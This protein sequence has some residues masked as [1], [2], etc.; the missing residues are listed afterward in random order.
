MANI[1]ARRALSDLFKQGTEIRFGPGPDGKPLGEIGPFLRESGERLPPSDDQVVMWITPAD[2]VQREQALREANARRAASIVRAKTDKESEEH[3][4]AMAFLVDMSDETLVDYVIIGDSNMR[5][6]QAE[7]EVLSD[8]EWKDMASYQDAMRQFQEMD[9]SELEG[10]PE[11]EALLELDEKYGAQVRERADELAET[12]REILRAQCSRDRASV[13]KLALNKRAEL[14]ASSVFMTEYDRWMTF[15]AVRE[16]DD[17]TKLFFESPTE[18]LR[19]P[20]EVKEL[21][22]TALIT[23]ISDAGE[24]KNSPGAADGSDSSVPPRRPAT[25]VASTPV[26]QTE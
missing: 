22:A 25:S 8:E 21:I 20:A 15:F 7:R 5:M 9:A 19:Q 23:Y 12:Q 24:A 1:K 2:P 4:T 18:Y 17:N 3:L 13:E 10:N 14:A 11:W 6:A 16:F 26:G